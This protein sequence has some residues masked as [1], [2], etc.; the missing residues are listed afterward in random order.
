MENGNCDQL[1][2]RPLIQKNC[3]QKKDEI[4]DDYAKVPKLK[5]P[6][7]LKLADNFTYASTF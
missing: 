6:Y 7:E 4:Q 2:H 5:A 3:T 1:Q